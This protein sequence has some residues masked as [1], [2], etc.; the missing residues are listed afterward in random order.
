VNDQTPP[1]GGWGVTMLKPIIILSLILASHL[2]IGQDDFKANVGKVL[3]L[4]ERNLSNEKDKP[5]SI[6][7]DFFVYDIS[8]DENGNVFD[9]H[10]LVFDSLSSKKS[11]NKISSM[12][13]QES[14]LGNSKY[15]KLI[16]PVVI[17]YPFEAFD[18]EKHKSAVKTLDFYE[19]LSKLSMEDFFV[20][21]IIFIQTYSNNKGNK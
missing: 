20:T 3:R 15:K 5:D 16:I 12:I 6:E 10:L 17:V 11:I 21:R 2:A 19:K 1:L 7:I 13:K 14:H 9:I 18:F 8:L 4:I